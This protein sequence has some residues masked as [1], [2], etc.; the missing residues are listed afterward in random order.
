MI[1]NEN[2]NEWF[3]ETTHDDSWRTIAEKLHTT[4]PT[5][6]RRLNNA[7]ADAIIELAVAYGA[8]PVEGLVAGGCIADVDV[9]SYARMYLTDDLTDLDLAQIIVERL[10]QRERDGD[11]DVQ[12][13]LYAVADSSEDE[14]EGD[15]GDYDA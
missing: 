11:T 12:S 4:H 5:I 1:N 9:R 10:E 13:A 3:T 8:N 14:E 7:E 6:K 2:F 15:P